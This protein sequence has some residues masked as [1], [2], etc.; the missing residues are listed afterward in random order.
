MKNNSENISIIFSNFLQPKIGLS[1]EYGSFVDGIFTCGFTRDKLVP[2]ESRV[3][4]LNKDWYILYA[5]GT[6]IEGIVER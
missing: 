3:F 6:A 5:Y 2:T 1:Q 4:N